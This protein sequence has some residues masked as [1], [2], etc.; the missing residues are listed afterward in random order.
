MARQQNRAGPGVTGHRAGCARRRQP[1]VPE[2]RQPAVPEPR[3]TI[4][5]VAPRGRLSKY[6]RADDKGPLAC[7]LNT[8]HESAARRRHRPEPG[9]R[10]ATTAPG[11]SGGTTRPRRCR[12]GPEDQTNSGV[13]L[14]RCGTREHSWSRA[15]GL[16]QSGGRVAAGHLRRHRGRPSGELSGVP[17]GVVRKCH[18]DNPPEATKSRRENGQNE[19][20]WRPH[21]LRQTSM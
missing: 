6:Q 8:A 7:S 19:P 2:S 14:A 4:E 17:R 5:P 20:C 21:M 9:Y 13:S 18:S 16:G 10:P 15:V 1:A 12:A 11:G 3:L